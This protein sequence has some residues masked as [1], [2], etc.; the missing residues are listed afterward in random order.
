MSPSMPVTSVELHLELD[1][2]L[3]RVYGSGLMEGRAGTGDIVVRVM[4]SLPWQVG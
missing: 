2:E 1:K 3:I 4:A